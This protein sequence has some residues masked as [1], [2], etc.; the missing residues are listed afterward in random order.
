L[1]DHATD[2][3]VAAGCVEL[4][5]EVPNATATTMASPQIF[6]QEDRKIGRDKQ[7]FSWISIRTKACEAVSIA[8]KTPSAPNPKNLD[9]FWPS[10]LPIFL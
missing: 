7:R 1:F 3:E 2:G 8:E 9:L 4:A 10:D 5:A 6:S